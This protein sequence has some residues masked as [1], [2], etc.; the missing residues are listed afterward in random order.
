VDSVCVIIRDIIPDQT[1]QMNVIENDQ[2]IEKLSATVSDPAFRDS[3]LSRACR[4]YAHGFYAVRSQHIGDLW[5][6]CTT[7]QDRVAVR[8]GFRKCFSR[9]LHYPGAGWVFRDVEMENLASI[10]FDDEETIRDWEREDRHG[11]EI[12]GRDDLA[13]IAQESSPEFPCLLGR[14]QAPHAARNCAFRDVKAEF[15]K[16]TMNPRSA[17]GGILLHHPPDESSNLGIGLWPA[18]GVFG[19]DRRRQNKRKPARCQATHGF[20]FDDNQDVAPCRPKAAEQS[21]EYSILDS[22]P[23]VRLFSLEYTQLLTESKNLKG[24]VVART[25]ESAAAG[26]DEMESWDGIYSIEACSGTALIA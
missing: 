17:P 14:R 2:T 4:A 1:A 13:V 26:K 8:T 25:E 6:T 20:W 7:I 3:I 15:A 19:F 23:R 5:R 9:L 22:Q 10:V 24:E 21:P 18:R 11:E 12:H 16:L